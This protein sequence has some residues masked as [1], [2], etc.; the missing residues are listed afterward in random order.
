MIGN[1]PTDIG[2]A[3]DLGPVRIGVEDPLELLEVL[4]GNLEVVNLAG[5]QVVE[6]LFKVFHIITSIKILT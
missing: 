2:L 5:T 1:L 3:F 6:L 4:R